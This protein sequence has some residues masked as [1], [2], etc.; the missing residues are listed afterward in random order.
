MW[1]SVQVGVHGEETSCITVIHTT[2]Y[3]TLPAK[4]P[5]F[6]LAYTVQY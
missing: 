5:G 3:L 4:M 1:E 6:C 2:G